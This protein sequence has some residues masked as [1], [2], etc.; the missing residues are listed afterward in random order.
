MV[1]VTWNVADPLPAFADG[2]DEPYETVVPKSKWYVVA[3]LFGS[4]A[5]LKFA[6]VEV[7][8]VA[9]AVETVGAV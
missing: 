7:T 4:T 8:V 3:R 2:V 1:E 6:P 9:A 5:P